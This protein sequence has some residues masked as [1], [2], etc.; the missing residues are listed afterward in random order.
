MGILRK[1]LAFLLL[2]SISSA[3]VGEAV[4]VG[5]VEISPEDFS[6]ALAPEDR[7]SKCL[8]CHGNQAGG[9]FDFGPEVHFGTPALRGMR[10]N[11]LRQSLVAYR[12]GS[13]R[14]EEMSAVAAMLDDETIKFMARSFA[15]YGAPPMR[16]DSD[17]AARPKKIPVSA[18]E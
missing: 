7:L 13:R 1:L 11:Y 8:A 17:L 4:Q 18:G 16:S 2:T 9:D 10:E 14:H 6:L 12:D 5:D 15:S 3:V